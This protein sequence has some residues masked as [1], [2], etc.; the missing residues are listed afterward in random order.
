MRVHKGR[1]EAGIA[2]FSQTYLTDDLM[3]IAVPVP[4]ML[5]DDDRSF[6]RCCR[7]VVSEA[8]K[9]RQTYKG[10]PHGMPTT[11]AHSIDG[12]LLAFIKN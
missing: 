4:V 2:A 7:T 10:F 6:P 1:I 8:T 11:H 9:G 5:G 12:D 3:Q